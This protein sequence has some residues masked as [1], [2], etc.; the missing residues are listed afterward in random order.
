MIGAATAGVCP[1]SKSNA[2]GEKQPGTDSK[3]KP[4]PGGDETPEARICRV[5]TGKTVGRYRIK[6]FGVA[7]AKNPPKLM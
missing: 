6:E 1:R 4:A 7:E 3:T 2:C 5:E